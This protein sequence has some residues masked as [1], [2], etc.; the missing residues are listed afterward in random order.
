MSGQTSLN[1][2]RIAKNTLLLYFRMLLTMAVSLFTS[3]AIL[4]TL[5]VEDYGIYNVVGGVV[6]MFG[7]LNSAMS[8]ATQRYITVVLGTGEISRLRDIFSIS[9]QI[10]ALISVMIIF[11]AETIGLWFLYHKMQIPAGRMDAAFWTYQ[12]SIVATVIMVMSVPYNSDIV[13]HEKMSAFAYISVLEVCLKL[14]IVYVLLIFKMDKLILYSILIVVVQLF[15]RICYSWY[16]KR[17]F[18][19]SHYRYVAN[20]KILKE[21]LNFAG[22]NL[23]GNVA[24]IAFSQGLNIL[25]NIFFGPVVN[26]ARAVALQV[27]SAI[28]QFVLNFQMALNPQIMKSY[29][30]SDLCYMHSLIYRSAKF[31]FFLL[32]LLSLPVLIETDYILTIWLKIVPDNTVVFLR[33]VLI[34]SWITAIANPLSNAAQATGTIRR[35]QSVIGGLLLLILPVSYICLKL[36]MPAYSVFVVHFIMECVAQTARLLIVRNLINISIRAYVSKV[37]ITIGFVVVISLIFP[38]ATHFVMEK[39]MLRLVIVSLI[40]IISVCSFSYLIG[41]NN[42]EKRFITAKVTEVLFKVKK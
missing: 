35:Y 11:F 10:H 39:G 37:F 26:A 42:S 27:Q 33:I 38:L 3:R 21:M 4:N 16:C 25:L 13:A 9:L 15:I 28:Q 14:A 41:L 7:F 23:W 24:Y 17:H 36:G 5:G 34:T 2:K 1:N 29:A 12:C 6:A 22:W 40:S 19:E 20:G 30:S 8:A 32:L 31:S 18:P